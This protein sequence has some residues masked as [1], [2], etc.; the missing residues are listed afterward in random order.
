MLKSSTLFSSEENFFEYRKGYSFIHSVKIWSI[1]IH[2]GKITRHIRNKT[3]KV[4]VNKTNTKKIH[5]DFRC[6]N[7]Q[8][9]SKKQLCL[10]YVKEYR[11]I[12]RKQKKY[13]TNK[14][15]MTNNQIKLQELKNTEVENKITKDGFNTR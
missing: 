11:S 3:S 2:E 10:L 12:H 4:R 15:N 8:T 5:K 7:Y 9:Q 13:K 6:W 14:T 1:H